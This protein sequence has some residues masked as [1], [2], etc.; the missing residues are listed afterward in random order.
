MSLVTAYVDGTADIVVVSGANNYRFASVGGE[1]WAVELVQALLG[2]D[3]DEPVAIEHRRTSGSTEELSRPS[4]T[5]TPTP[6]A[7]CPNC[8]AA[9]VIVPPGGL[10]VDC[11]RTDS[12]SGDCLVEPHSVV[13]VHSD[14]YRRSASMAARPLS[15]GDGGGGDLVE[16]LQKLAA[17]HQAGLLSEVGNSPPPNGS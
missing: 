8:D 3:D 6:T 10:C 14:P 17:L 13:E 16:G 4:S 2:L 15:D 5:T 11:A 9:Y 1:E 12:P 7:I